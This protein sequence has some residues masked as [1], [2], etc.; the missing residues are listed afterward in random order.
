MAEFKKDGEDTNEYFMDKLPVNMDLSRLYVLTMKYTA[1]ASEATIIGLK[2]YMNII[3]IGETTHGK[4]YGGGL[5]GPMIY[6]TGKKEWV[7]DKQID[8]W[9]L[10]LML[11]RYANKYGDTSF[12]GGLVPD[13]FAEEDYFPLYPLGDERDPLFGKAVAMITGETVKTRITKSIPYPHTIEDAKLRNPI[14]KKMIYNVIGI[15][16]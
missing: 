14:K 9:L 7:T 12:S 3:Q 11:Y 15:P 2:P 16:L 10:Y 1:S 4:Y 6:D 13:V 5:L 8:N